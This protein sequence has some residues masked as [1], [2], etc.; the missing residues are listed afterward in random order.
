MSLNYAKDNT[1][2]IPVYLFRQGRNCRAYDFFGSHFTENGVVFR[3]WAPKAQSVSVVGEF[4]SWNDA[5]NV[6]VKIADGI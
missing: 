5:A 6:M 3:V 2:D 4:N 1:S